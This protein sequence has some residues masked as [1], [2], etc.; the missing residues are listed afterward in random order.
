MQSEF[1]LLGLGAFFAGLVDAVVGGGGL[2]QIPLLLSTFP[3][4]PPSI[5]FGTNKIASIVGTTSAA[6]RYAKRVE[7][8]ATVV[9]IAVIAAL[10]GAWWGAQMVSLLSPSTIRPL[11]LVLLVIVGIYTFMNKGFGDRH[12]VLVP[13]RKVNLTAAIVGLVIGVYDGFFGP[14]TGSFLIFAFV[15]L[16]G[17][18]ML[19]ASASAKF[20]NVATNIAALGY[21][22]SHDGVI[23]KLGLSMAVCNLLG[24]QAGAY[25]ALKHGNALVRKLFL[26]VVAL[27]IAKFGWG[28]ITG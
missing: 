27:L 3:Q 15:R 19:H 2:I 24:A 17:M 26:I 28:L 6:W 12:T 4:V 16:F 25:I 20:V 5:L 13:G 1:L 9:S 22:I 7:I 8:N 18:D 10:I 21:F 14:G 11:V 23:W